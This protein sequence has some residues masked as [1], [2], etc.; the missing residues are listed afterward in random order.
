M[1]M[2]IC[3]EVSWKEVMEV[4]KCLKRGKAAGPDGIMNKMLMYGGGWL[5]VVM[6]LMMNV[7]MKS[8]CSPLDWK[9]SLLVPLHKDSGVKQVGNYRRIAL[10]CSVVKVFM[11]VL[12]R[13][14]ERFAEDLTET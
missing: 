14:L 6:L 8:E 13:K 1:G 10:G 11:R 4:M 3:E 12:A 7:V 2:V 9:R 5:V